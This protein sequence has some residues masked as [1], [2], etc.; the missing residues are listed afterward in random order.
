MSC[1]DHI[2]CP[3]RYVTLHNQKIL[4]NHTPTVEQTLSNTYA[5]DNVSH[6]TMKFLSNDLKFR[7]PSTNSK[8]EALH[9]MF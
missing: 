3:I 6:V 9:F 7:I 8:L 5:H 2:E 1:H 4:G